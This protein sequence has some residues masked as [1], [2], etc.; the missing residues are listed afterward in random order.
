[1][2]ILTVDVN[3]NEYVNQINRTLHKLE[4]SALHCV[5]HFNNPIV[6]SSAT[7]A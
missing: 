4:K 2:S 3:D 1:M 7:V 5:L 6:T